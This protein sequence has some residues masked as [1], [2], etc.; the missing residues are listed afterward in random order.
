MSNVL[1]FEPLEW[2]IIGTKYIWIKP[3]P[4]ND[5]LRLTKAGPTNLT[6]YTYPGYNSA[7]YPNGSTL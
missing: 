1:V 4:Q 6:H 3:R 2:Y 5:I 7:L